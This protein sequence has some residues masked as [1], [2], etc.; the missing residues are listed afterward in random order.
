M[1]LALL[2]NPALYRLM[3]TIDAQLASAT[4][5]K[6]CKD[7]G[8]KLHDGGFRRKPRGCPERFREAFSWRT[9]FD[10][11]RCRHRTKPP[12]MRFLGARVY[13]SA[14]VAL[15]SPPGQASAPWLAEALGVSVRTVDRW[16]HWWRHDFLKT[17]TWQALRGRFLPPLD[18]QTLPT[19]LLERLRA[20][21]PLQRLIRMLKLLTSSGPTAAHPRTAMKHTAR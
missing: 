13:H 6:G 9:S 21:S 14:M 18:T 5:S 17:Q 1:T 10:C 16:R 7:C 12:A 19:S 20:P 11:S 3:L 2:K 15:V 4:R 8:R